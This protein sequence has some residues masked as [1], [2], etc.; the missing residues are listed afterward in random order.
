MHLCNNILQRDTIFESRLWPALAFH[1]ID[2]FTWELC[3]YTMRARR[4]WIS[5]SRHVG[6]RR[7]RERTV[8]VAV[9]RAFEQLFLPRPNAFVISRCQKFRDGKNLPHPQIGKI[10][11]CICHDVIRK[12]QF[13]FPNWLII[14]V[15]PTNLGKSNVM[16]KCIGGKTSFMLCTERKTLWLGCVTLSQARARTWVE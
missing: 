13:Y 11:C 9:A 15:V 4:I 7:K 12:L 3:W 16:L 14:M 6:G 10:I 5:R 2:H 8:A 1:F